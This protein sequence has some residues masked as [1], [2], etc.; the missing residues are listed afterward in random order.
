MF[1]GERIGGTIHLAPGKGHPETESKNS[2]AIHWDLVC[3][4][5]QG[6]RI[7]IDGEPFLVDGKILVD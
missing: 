5:R 1:P 3:G 4:L 2:S 7:E 6:G